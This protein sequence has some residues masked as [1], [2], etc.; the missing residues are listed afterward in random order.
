MPSPW[1][2]FLLADLVA[3]MDLGFS[4][5]AFHSSN[6]LVFM[7]AQLSRSR[8]SLTITSPPNN[9]IYPPGP[10]ML[11]RSGLDWLWCTFGRQPLFSW[12]WTMSP[13]QG[14]GWLSDL[15]PH[16]QFKIRA[17]EFKVGYQL[18]SCFSPTFI[19]LWLLWT[20]YYL[21]FTLE[22]ID[23]SFKWQNEDIVDEHHYYTKYK[24]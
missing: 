16:L 8:K 14:R 15:E 23:A 3:L 21:N 17:S 9:R 2:P 10:G 13:V 6:R 7:E 24:G 20:S 12:Q 1:S 5:H 11:I 18:S 4:S 22:R 19:L